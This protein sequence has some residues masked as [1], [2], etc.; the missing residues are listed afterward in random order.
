ML[1]LYQNRDIMKSF[2]F[3]FLIAT[4][5]ITTP[6]AFTAEL[7]GDNQKYSYA[8]G[9]RV[10]NM[11]RK[12][13]TDDIDIQTFTQAIADVLSGKASK[14]TP[15]QS[16]AAMSAYMKA[17]DEKR[18]KLAAANKADG[19]KFRDS[20]A[21]EEGVV[22]LENG[23]Q[24]KVITAGEG[25]TPKPEQKVEVHY[26]G[27]LINGDEFDSSYK[28]GKPAQFNLNGVVPGFREA[29]V[30]MKPGAKWEVVM[31]PELAYGAKGAGSNIGPNET[32][33]FEI[34]LLRIVEDKKPK[35]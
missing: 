33:I 28:R 4:L 22:T 34:E 25:E 12:Q 31:P 27:R 13:V 19:E 7:E 23:L 30:R 14:L 5:L 17:Q 26:S 9:I 3:F 24:Y 8:I 2:Q 20:N 35:S 10:G 18:E 32:L 1:I 16:K 29:I 21:T 6:T 15:E 11:L